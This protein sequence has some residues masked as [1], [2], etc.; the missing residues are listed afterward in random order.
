MGIVSGLIFVAAVP[1]PNEYYL[2]PATIA[3]GLVYDLVLYS[4]AGE[5]KAGAASKMRVLAGSGISGV[6]ESITA[7]S[8]LTFVSGYQFIL[9]V[10]VTNVN[11][12][13]IYWAIDLPLN[14]ILSIVGT[15]IAVGF[16][17]QRRRVAARESQEQS[18]GTNT[19]EHG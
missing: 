8:I 3:A 12:V 2:L 5:Y 1:A 10:S 14:A 7:L 16:M 15:S 4:G 9:P 17:L 13:L 11:P 6:A 18:A 19:P